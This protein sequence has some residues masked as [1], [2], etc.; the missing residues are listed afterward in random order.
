M[1][2]IFIFLKD[3]TKVEKG[4]DVDEPTSKSGLK[5]QRAGKE[6]AS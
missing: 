6:V 5:G 2:K 1:L 3:D 4:K